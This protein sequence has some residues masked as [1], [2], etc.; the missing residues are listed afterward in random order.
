MKL[1]RPRVLAM[2]LAMALA[3][4]ALTGVASNVTTH[5]ATAAPAA[6]TWQKFNNVKLTL[7]DCWNGGV[8]LPANQDGNMVATAI[9]NKIGV[10][11]EY[12]GIMMSEVDKLNMMFASGDFP[13]IV[14]A[15]YWGGSGGETGVIKKAATEGMILPLN[16]Y[17]SGNTYPNVKAGFNVGVISKGFQQND[18]YDPEFK[19]NIYVIPSQTQ[20]DVADITNW[21]Y[22]IFCRADILKA[23]NITPSSVKT[24]AQLY[25]LMTKIKNG[26]FK[27]VNGKPVIPAT[28]FHNG[29]DISGYEANYFNLQMSSFVKEANGTT[30]LNIFDPSWENGALFINK[31]VNEGI[32]DKECFTTSDD[33]ANQKVGNGTAAMFSAQYGIGI[34]ATVTSGLYT[35]HPEMRYVPLGPL[36][37]ANGQPLVQTSTNGRNG[38]PAYFLPKTCKNPAAA[39]T[40]LDYVNSK[41]GL[42]LCMYGVQGKTYNLNAQG[43]PRLI[44]RLQNGLLASDPTITTEILNDG[45]NFYGTGWIIAQKTMTWWGEMSAGQSASLKPEQVAYNKARPVKII[46][47]TPLDQYSTSFPQ[48][49]KV[50][51][52]Y[53]NTQDQ[54]TAL[55]QAYLA[56]NA[57]AAKKILDTYLAKMKALDGGVLLKYAQYAGTQAKAHSDALY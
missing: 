51:T 10:T 7:L 45:M 49:D 24:T 1:K 6:Q 15:P 13:D 22:G 14:N 29:W 42:L 31:L 16:K 3:V 5:A 53:S 32:M 28:T 56:P 17:L 39:L 25:S 11:V 38:T 37:Y 43:Q 44:P 33:L 52:D 30:Q 26:N 23:L 48:Y 27:D 18:V 57:A 36:N 20:G 12:Q 54:S 34:T 8:K 55:N 40:W 41:E 35:A 50:S 21:G 9:R 46:P 2:S 4:T 47:G 19:G